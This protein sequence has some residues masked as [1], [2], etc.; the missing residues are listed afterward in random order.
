MELIQSLPSLDSP[1]LVPVHRFSKSITGLS[2][3][4]FKSPLL[5][6]LSIACLSPSL[7]NLSLVEV[8]HLPD[9]SLVYMS[10][11][12]LSPLPNLSLVEVHHLPNLSLVQVYHLT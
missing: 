10:I 6:D 4:S 11:A 1:S 9:L 3:A 7:H 8:H 12:C 5:P 2:P